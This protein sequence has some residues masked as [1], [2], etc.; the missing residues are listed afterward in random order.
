M[1][2]PAKIRNIALVGHRGTGKTSLFEALLFDAGAITRLG[3]VADGTTVSDW[4][5]DEKKRQMSL[6]AGLA[7]VDREGLSFN[8]I[9]TPGDSSFLADAIASLQVVETALVVVN[10]V[11]GVEVQHE[12]LWD[13]AEARGLGRVI[14]CNM[15]DRERADF[16]HALGLLQESFGAA[17][18]RRAAAH[19]Q[20]AR[21][22]RRRRPA[23]DEG[24]HVQGRQ[25][26]RGRHPRGARRRRRRGS[27]Q[28]HRRRRE[29]RRRPRREV[30]H[31]RGDHGGR[32]QRG[33]RRRRRR[34][35]ALPGRLR[36]R[37]GQH[38]RGSHLRRARARPVARRRHARP[39]P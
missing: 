31:G 28:A 17:G 32:A 34:R 3:S 11:L 5:D 16:D 26:D 19:R 6:S 13:R 8:L 39:R 29:H 22:Q 25:G 9:D 4:D 1:N 30:P 14:V 15:L 10:T 35:S 33:V 20:G 21:V 27:R 36:V 23:H 38:R 18:R 12:R 24:A 37:D 7:H 2:D